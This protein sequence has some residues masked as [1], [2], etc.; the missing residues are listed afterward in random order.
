[1]HLQLGSNGA[2]IPQLPLWYPM[3]GK[4]DGAHKQK[5]KYI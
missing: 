4:H 5:S 3:D 2:Q 1:M